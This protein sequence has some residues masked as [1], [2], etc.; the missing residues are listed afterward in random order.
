MIHASTSRSVNS[1]LRAVKLAG[2]HISFSDKEKKI[3]TF[4]II[5]NIFD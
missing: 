2:I 4:M 3:S 5:Q 1:G